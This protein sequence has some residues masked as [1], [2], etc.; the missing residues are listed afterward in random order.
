VC[1][2]AEYTARQYHLSLYTTQA[3]RHTDVL[4]T[5]LSFLW[6]ALILTRRKA[7][8]AAIL[9]SRGRILGRWRWRPIGILPFTLALQ[10]LS[11]PFKAA[12]L[13]F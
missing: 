3:T 12:T 7:G 11:L 13:L 9:A 6:A 5:T 1:S 10:A 8:W 2:E 4:A